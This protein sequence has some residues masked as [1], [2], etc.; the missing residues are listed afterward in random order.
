[1]ALRT[2]LGTLCGYVGIYK[3]HRLWGK[4]YGDCLE[5]RSRPRLSRK[6]L[7]DR[8]RRSLKAGKRG[9]KLA[10][11]NMQLD[12]VL[13]GR[14]LKGALARHTY[15]H[16]YRPNRCRNYS[17]TTPDSIF[18]VHG[19]ITFADGLDDRWDF[20]P[21]RRRPW[22]FGFDCAH[23]WD[24]IPKIA[25]ALGRGPRKDEQYR[26]LAFVQEECRSLAKQLKNYR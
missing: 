11:L 2:D 10:T 1:M 25:E 5:S 24:F 12:K 13:R 16:A 19:G 26:D 22:Y 7:K 6:K 20:R 15:R 4:R 14:G 3:P 8:L 21:E 23:A 18:Q 9:D 17:H